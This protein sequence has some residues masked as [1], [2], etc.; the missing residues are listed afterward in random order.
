MFSNLHNVA[1]EKVDMNSTIALRATL[2]CLGPP[3]RKTRR[4]C[5]ELTERVGL[6]DPLPQITENA[7]SLTKTKGNPLE[8]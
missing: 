4:E 7:I 6:A 5:S 8:I 2:P 3:T 1:F